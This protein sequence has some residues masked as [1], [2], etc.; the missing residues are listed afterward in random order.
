MCGDKCCDTPD[1]SNHKGKHADKMTNLEPET[2]VPSLNAVAVGNCRIN[3]NTIPTPLTDGSIGSYFIDEETPISNRQL[4][5]ASKFPRGWYEQDQLDS[6]PSSARDDDLLEISHDTGTEEHKFTYPY[7]RNEGGDSAYEEDEDE[8]EDEEVD[9][10]DENEEWDDDDNEDEIENEGELEEDE[11][12]AIEPEE[13]VPEDEN[14]DDE[15][16]DTHCY[17]TGSKRPSPSQQDK[18]PRK[19]GRP[20][21]PLLPPATMYLSSIDNRYIVRD[22]DPDL[23]RFRITLT[24]IIHRLCTFARQ[25]TKEWFHLPREQREITLQ[26]R[27]LLS[28]MS[29]D[30]LLHHI[31]SGMPRV[32]Q[33]ILGKLS[34]EPIDLL[35]LPKV[36]FNFPHRLVYAD[37]ATRIPLSNV[38]RG[39]S[40]LNLRATSVKKLREGANSCQASEINIYIGSSISKRGGRDRLAQHEAMAMD[41][42]SEGA[43]Y[44]FITQEDVIPNF[45]LL[46]MWENPWL[47]KAVDQD[48]T[49]SIPIFCEGLMMTYLNLYSGNPNPGRVPSMYRPDASLALDVYLRDGLGLPELGSFSLNRAWPLVQGCPGSAIQAY[50]CANKQCGKSTRFA[51]PGEIKARCL[52]PLLGTDPLGPRYC[53]PCVRRHAKEGTL[54]TREGIPNGRLHENRHS[55]VNKQWFANGNPRKCYNDACGVAIPENAFLYGYAKGIRCFR[56]DKHRRTKYEEWNED[57]TVDD[58]D[59]EEGKLECSACQSQCSSRPYQWGS[60]ILC[61]K[62][63]QVRCCFDNRTRPKDPMGPKV[64]NTISRCSNPSCQSHLPSRA[65]FSKFVEDT[66]HNVWRCLVCDWAWAL[67]GLEVPEGLQKD[68]ELDPAP[69]GPIAHHRF[70]ATSC[71]GCGQYATPCSWNPVEGGGFNCDLC[72]R[73]RQL[74][75]IFEGLSVPEKVCGNPTCAKNSNNY[76][77]T[78]SFIR[79]VANANGNVDLLRCDMCLSYLRR[80]KGDRKVIPKFRVCGNTACDRNSSNWDG[81]FLTVGNGNGRDASKRDLNL[82]RC[83]RCYQY[84]RI[85]GHDHT[86]RCQQPD[87]KKCGNPSCDRNSDNYTGN[88]VWVPGH[89]GDEEY[90]RCGAC[91]SYLKTHRWIEERVPQPPVPDFRICGNPNCDNDSSNHPGRFYYVDGRSGDEDFTRCSR[92]YDYFRNHDGEERPPGPPRAPKPDIRTCRNPK[93][94]NN[95]S[96]YTGRWL[97]VKNHSGDEEYVRCSPCYDHLRNH[98]GKE[99]VPGP[100]KPTYRKCR[101]PNCTSDSNTYP[102]RWSFL[103]GHKG[104]EQYLRCDMCMNYWKAH[105]GA[106]R[107]PK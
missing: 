40:E 56:C 46:G 94:N 32:T 6:G 87:F 79:G 4:R 10:W 52:L 15:I 81:E 31:I 63:N 105:N 93:C 60:E 30:N 19:G 25:S 24:E 58:Y 14:S 41:P 106:D 62:C 16:D 13:K 42:G 80:G 78:F 103:P 96:N 64:S 27:S 95:S 5:R 50:R 2:P 1:S 23:I 49:R 82:M 21:D 44:Q 83:K 29:P 22:E 38:V 55:A 75:D 100:P 48:T 88:W 66:K 91:Y 3:E 61:S 43:H 90:R 68:I 98:K 76:Q 39:P 85:H 53:L 67:F 17:Q 101:N 34:L 70:N 18:G 104:D 47:G 28:K 74:P 11:F 92:C 7:D 86:P 37:V 107:P 57:D 20:K 102:R 97:Y 84:Y 36:P 54:P 89:Y 9:E 8:D 51:I 45:H 72:A 77:G 12:L 73:R 33:K 26:F 35:G 59:E 71:V 99:R 69:P 65:G